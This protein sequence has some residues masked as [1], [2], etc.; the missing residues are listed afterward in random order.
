MSSGAVTEKELAF[1]FS[2]GLD[3]VTDDHLLHEGH[4]LLIEKAVAPHDDALEKVQACERVLDGLE[5]LMEELGEGLVV[6]LVDLG[7]SWDLGLDGGDELGHRV[8]DETKLRGSFT[9]ENGSDLSA[10]LDVT[11]VS[12]SGQGDRVP[13]V[14]LNGD[15][16]SQGD[17]DGLMGT[18]LEVV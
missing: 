5:D 16:M 17:F 10:P 9:D 15:V 18:F 7:L 14:L 3:V 8:L 13:E 12:D 11:S 4:E 1:V 2:E 6:L